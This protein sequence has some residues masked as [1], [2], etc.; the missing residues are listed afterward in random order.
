M[1]SGYV[2]AVF[3]QRPSSLKRMLAGQGSSGLSRQLRKEYLVKV[4]GR[5][6]CE[7]KGLVLP[8]VNTL[9]GGGGEVLVELLLSWWHHGS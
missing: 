4:R 1:R 9:R 5:A 7:A 2:A 6:G 3:A 8:S